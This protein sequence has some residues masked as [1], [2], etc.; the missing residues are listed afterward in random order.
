MCALTG[1]KLSGFQTSKAMAAGKT[2]AAGVETAKKQNYELVK[3]MMT[4]QYWLPENK[5]M[6]S[7]DISLELPNAPPG[8]PQYFNPVDF[9]LYADWLSQTVKTWKV[10]SGYEIL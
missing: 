10:N 1:E 9:R 6:F 3:R 5:G 2:V 4:S 8:M 7:S